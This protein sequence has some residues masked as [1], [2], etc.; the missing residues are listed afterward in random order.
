MKNSL[1]FT[2]KSAMNWLVWGAVAVTLGI[3][4]TLNDPINAPK[5]WVLSIVAFWLIGWLVFQIQ[6]KFD[7]VALRIAT[8]C[9]GLFL[10]SMFAAFLATDNKF[11][12]FFGAY[13]RRTGF[14]TYLGLIVLFLSATYLI[15]LSTLQI[16][17]KASLT[18][19]LFLGIYGFAQHY[20]F[21]PIN[22]NNPYNSVIDTLGNPDFA[23]ACMALFLILNFG[24][25]LQREKKYWVRVFAGLNTLLLLIVIFFSQVRQG[26]LVS[27][28]GV[29]IVLVVYTYQRNKFIG[30]ALAG[31]TVTGGFVSVMG[32]LDKGPLVHFFYKT[33]VT[34]RGDYWRAG[35]NMFKHHIL[36]GVG[37]DRYG[38]NFREYR[39]LN[40]VLRRGPN[41]V[42]N[43]AHNVPLQ[44]ASTGGIF[45]ITTYLILVSFVLWR[46][47]V[48][49]RKTTGNEQILVVVCL[50]AWVGYQAQSLISIDNIGIAVWGYLLGGAVVGLSVT[51]HSNQTASPVFSAKALSSIISGVLAT[52]AIVFSILLFKAEVA[53][54]NS[55]GLRPPTN[56]QEKIAFEKAVSAPLS[57][58]FKDPQFEFLVSLR[59]A[60][61]NDFQLATDKLKNLILSDPKNY[62]ALNLLA[63]IYEFKSDWQHAILYRQK[64]AKSDPLNTS[65]FLSLAEDYKKSG[66]VDQAK[67][68]IRV[69]AAID[70]NSNESKQ[71]LKELG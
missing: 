47:M 56:Q 29:I 71:A 48:A 40:Q 7:E 15:R 36:F 60:Q 35:W 25:S 30:I 16:L 67:A 18:L 13:Q 27:L 69:I 68:L 1:S 37:L 28:L 8:I 62:D 52:V 9:A 20:K 23:A 39:D 32:M 44:L 50:A 43:A 58:G 34:F 5:S 45:V 21:D 65:N 51:P 4:T 55:L 11:I 14:L 53:I 12:G 54:H 6:E 64:M 31:L 57:Y 26:L 10:L 63:E 42:S 17:E 33:S 41:V 3:W 38:A 2:R 24:I 22:W 19:G 46:G 66:S 59:L 61:G 70:P 49:L